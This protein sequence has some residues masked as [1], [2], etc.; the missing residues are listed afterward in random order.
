MES[1]IFSY[2]ILLII[3][4]QETGETGETASET[5]REGYILIL[6]VSLSLSLFL[7]P[8][9]WSLLLDMISLP[10]TPPR[11]NKKLRNLF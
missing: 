3:E 9:L 8:G 6:I 11:S 4:R 1:P 7:S 5:H 10:N 2:R